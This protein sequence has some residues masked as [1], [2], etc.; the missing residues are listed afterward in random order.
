MTGSAPPE[1]E[2]E[3]RRLGGTGPLVLLHKPLACELLAGALRDV[4]APVAA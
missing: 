1:G 3:L 4:V 2:A